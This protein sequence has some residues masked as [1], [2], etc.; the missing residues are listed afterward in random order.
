MSII[1]KPS[2]F[3]SWRKC[4]FRKLADLPK[5]APTPVEFCFDCTHPQVIK[6]VG[7]YTPDEVVKD[8]FFGETQVAVRIV[9]GPVNAPYVEGNLSGWC[10]N[11]PLPKS[12]KP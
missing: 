4:P 11:C 10:V 6:A 5:D 3:H 8:T 2:G 7:T 1:E 12:L 9:S